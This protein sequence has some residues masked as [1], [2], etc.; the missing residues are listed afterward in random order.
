VVT[1]KPMYVNKNSRVL[2]IDQCGVH[3][4][5]R[6]MCRMKDVEVSIFDSTSIKVRGG[7]GFCLKQ[8]GIL[9][10]ILPSSSNQISIFLHRVKANI[11]GYFWL[12]F[13]IRENEWVVPR[14]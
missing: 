10:F 7:V 5:T 4:E 3:H 13:F 8:G 14:C 6:K 11:L 2:E 9:L 1:P 12:S